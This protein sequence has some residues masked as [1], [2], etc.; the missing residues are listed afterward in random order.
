MANLKS[1]TTQNFNDAEKGQTTSNVYMRV[2][3]F[4]V[5]PFRPISFGGTDYTGLTIII[6]EFYY[7]VSGTERIIEQGTPEVF[8]LPNDLIET[9]KSNLS[10]IRDTEWA[11]REIEILTLVLRNF[12]TTRMT[13]P[14]F[15]LN[16][17]TSW[18]LELPAKS[19]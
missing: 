2:K 16:T 1:K 13:V 6:P 3:S 12:I 9:I 17:E 19:K 8:Y 5:D 18:D 10:S 15:G 4:T 14:L 7:L 11:D